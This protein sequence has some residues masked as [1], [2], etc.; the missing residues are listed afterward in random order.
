MQR[1]Q[2]P[3][4]VED[5]QG[6]ILD[7]WVLLACERWTENR[8]GRLE[9]RGN[10]RNKQRNPRESGADPEI[11]LKQ[12][13]LALL[14]ASAHRGGDGGARGL[15]GEAMGNGGPSGQGHPT[16]HM[17]ASAGIPSAGM[18]RDRVAG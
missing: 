3:V 4:T 11:S 6:F 13:N 14:R 18:G 12:Q 16:K 2:P 17:D 7:G 5:N 9:E 15:R 8:T 1:S 10:N